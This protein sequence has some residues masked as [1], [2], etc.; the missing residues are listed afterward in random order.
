MSFLREGSALRSPC[1]CFGSDLPGISVDFALQ[2]LMFRGHCAVRRQPLNPL[3]SAGC[4]KIA[5]AITCSFVCL[6][7]D[8]STALSFSAIVIKLNAVFCLEE[9][10]SVFDIFSVPSSPQFFS[11]DK[12]F[13]SLRICK[14]VL[15]TTARFFVDR[16]HQDKMHFKSLNGVV[17]W[18]DGPQ[19]RQRSTSTCIRRRVHRSQTKRPPCGGP[20]CGLV[21][22]TTTPEG[23]RRTNIAC[24][25]AR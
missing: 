1:T 15:Q 5:F 23:D 21:I 14:L 6:Y 18:W 16:K 3:S 13:E 4:P 24:H 12:R 17:R 7:K 20:D 9:K 11:F 8:K 10:T 22:R 19:S 25:L 2:G